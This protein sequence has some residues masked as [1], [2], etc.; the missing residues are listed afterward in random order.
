MF[1]TY[2][3]LSLNIKNNPQPIRWLEGLFNMHCAICRSD[4]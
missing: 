4:S 2:S 3:L 1:E